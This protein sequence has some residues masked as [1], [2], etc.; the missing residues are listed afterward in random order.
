MAIIW[1]TRKLTKDISMQGY[2]NNVEVP[3]DD[4]DLCVKIAKQMLDKYNCYP[5]FYKFDGKI[6]CRISAQIYNE[7]SDY[8]FAANT[9]LHLLQQHQN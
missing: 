5:I 1:K 7:L 6:F 9:F 3:S 4:I 2:L 8:E